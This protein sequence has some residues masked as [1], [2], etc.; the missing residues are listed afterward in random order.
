LIEQLIYVN[1]LH[2][3]QCVHLFCLNK[4]RQLEFAFDNRELRTVCENRRKAEMMF[5]TDVAQNL[6]DRLADLRAAD[7]IADLIVGNPQVA[8]D[9]EGQS[10]LSIELINNYVIILT[11]NHIELPK[12]ESGRPDWTAVTRLKVMRIEKRAA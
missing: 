11:P 4:S 10:N 5:G 7:S 8:I 9:S 3:G 12:D 2:E 1:S 6:F